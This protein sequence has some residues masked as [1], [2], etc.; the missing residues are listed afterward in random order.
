MVIGWKVGEL[1][2]LVKR[3][4]RVGGPYGAARTVVTYSLFGLVPV[5]RRSRAPRSS[6][7][8]IPVPTPPPGEQVTPSS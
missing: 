5:F 6:Y 3:K 4:R 7:G 8:Y 2:L 1:A